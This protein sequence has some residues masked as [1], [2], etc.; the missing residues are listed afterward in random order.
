MKYSIA[1]L[2]SATSSLEAS[3]PSRAK[4]NRA[5][6]TAYYALYHHL[7]DAAVARLVG[8]E[9]TP[10][11]REL[12]RTLSRGFD[13]ARMKKVAAWFAPRTQVPKEI[14][15]LLGQTPASPTGFVPSKLANVA[16]A[17]VELQEARH[18]ADYDIEKRFTRTEARA[19]VTR[20]RAAI[21]D[22]STVTRATHARLFLSLFIMDDKATQPRV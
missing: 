4:I 3:R 16:H 1:L 12:R 13:H 9:R 14:M 2:A 20:A 8:R 6:S 11:A 22:W 10:A 18:A 7:I 21:G 5:I 15:A 19:L 17:F